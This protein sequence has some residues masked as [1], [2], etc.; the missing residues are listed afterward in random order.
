MLNF[1]NNI[2]TLVYGNS[3]T[4]KTTLCLQTALKFGRLGKV[5]FID[6][7]NSFSLDRLKQMDSNCD[8]YLEN[9]VVIK[10]KD[11]EEQHNV[12][13]NIKQIIKEGKIKIIIIDTIGM[14]YRLAL[15]EENYID[16]N[17]KLLYQLKILKHLTDE[18]NIPVLLTNQVYT[19][20]Q[21]KNIGVGGNMIARFGKRLI[22]L[23]K[24]PRKAVF[25][26]P[27]EKII[28]FELVNEGLRIV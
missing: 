2:I 10:V 21:G 19:N 11:F 14:H 5:L 28:N 6:T 8:R 9:I 25:I 17:D 24:N 18:Y 16:I 27:E 22:E 1:E 7:E 12:F 15:Q 4:G 13:K 3:A 26:K 23:K 20:M